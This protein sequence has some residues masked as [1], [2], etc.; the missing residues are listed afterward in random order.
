MDWFAGESELTLRATELESEEHLKVI[1]QLPGLLYLR[2]HHSAYTGTELTFSASE[3]PSLK[4]L[5][6]H[7]GVY[8]ALNLRFEEG[9]APKL[10]RLELS[11]FE[12]ASIRKPSGINFLANLQEVL[13]HADPSD[14]SEDMVRY[15]MDEASRNPNQPTVTFKAKQW[16][17]ARTGP[18]IDY[19]GNIWF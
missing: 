15:L 9:T 11:F 17:S 5:T 8:Q 7:L 2:L 3:F 6:I 1:S 18:A 16:K 10:H 19:R 4:L 12:R 14:N 13:V